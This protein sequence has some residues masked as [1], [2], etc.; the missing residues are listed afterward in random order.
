M[1]YIS[2]VNA[3]IYSQ[4]NK[5]F[6]TKWKGRTGSTG[7]EWGTRECEGSYDAVNFICE[8][9]YGISTFL[10]YCKGKVLY[11]AVSSPQDYRRR[12]TFH[13]LTD[14]YN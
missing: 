7:S 1:I 6:G 8:N 4:K 2:M 9:Y 11:N 5:L 14:L 13:F 10:V 3:S 12:F